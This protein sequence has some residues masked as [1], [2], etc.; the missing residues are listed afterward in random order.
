MKYG[1]QHLKSSGWRP[2]LA[3]SLWMIISS[4]AGDAKLQI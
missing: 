2:L 1:G 3:L 4:S